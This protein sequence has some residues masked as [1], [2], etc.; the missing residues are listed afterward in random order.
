MSTSGD[1][2][3]AA[4]DSPTGMKGLWV[5]RIVDALRDGEV[6]LAVHSA[7]DLPA[8]ELEGVVIGA[9]PERADPLDVL[10]GREERLVPGMVVGTSSVR[11]RAQLLAGFPGMGVT[12]IRGNVDT[13]S[14]SSP[15]ARSTG[16]CWPRPVSRASGW[17]CRTLAGSAS[18]RW[19]GAG[20]GSAGDPRPRGG[21]HDARRHLGARPRPLPPCLGGRTRPRAAPRRR[22]RPAARGVRRDEGRPERMVALV[23]TPDGARSCALPRRAPTQMSRRPPWRCGCAPRARTGSCPSSRVRKTLAGRTVLVTRPA[24]QAAPLVRELERRGARVLVAPTIRLVPC[25]PR[26]HVGVEGPGRRPLRVDRA[27]EPDDGAG[28]P[29][30]TRVVSRRPRERRGDRRRHGLCLPTLGPARSGSDAVDVHD[31]RPRARLPAWLGPRPHGS[32]RHRA[33]RTRGRARA[34]RLGR[35]ASMPIER[36][37]PALPRDA[38]TALRRGEVDVVTFTSASTVEGSC[39]RSPVPA[40]PRRSWRSDR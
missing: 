4:T 8:E 28:P 35:S 22:L 36:C 13:R 20:A 6:D 19:S 30:S 11:R 21:P 10:I 17:T 23:A 29:R 1:E 31:R 9:V 15:T 26:P 12:E 39:E 24:E 5:D 34:E 3:A 38:A 16:S 25:A 18:T 7:K 2:G 14:G 40:A 27:H 33:T 37:S 32:R